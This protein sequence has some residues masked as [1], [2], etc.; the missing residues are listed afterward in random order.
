MAIILGDSYAYDSSIF[1]CSKNAD[2]TVTLIAEASDLRYNKPRQ[3]YDDA[4]DVGIAIRSAR[5]GK[6]IRF[7]LSDIDVSDEDVAGWHF[8]PIPEDMR[9]IPESRNVRV[10]IIND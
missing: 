6:L 7:Y 8:A 4:A 1:T 5:T 10:L 9:R 2:G 3:I